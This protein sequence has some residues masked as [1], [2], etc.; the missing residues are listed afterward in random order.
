MN[1]GFKYK[2]GGVAGITDKPA[3]KIL[4]WRVRNYEKYF[5]NP[6]FS[7]LPKKT[8]IPTSKPQSK[9]IV[10]VIGLCYTICYE[11]MLG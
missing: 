8:V 9:G 2:K 3:Q 1:L 6:R 10:I 4:T 7:F 5:L 11:I